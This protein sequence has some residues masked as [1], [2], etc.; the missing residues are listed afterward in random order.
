MPNKIFDELLKEKTDIFKIAFSNISKQIFWDDNKKQLIHPG[1]YGTYREAV[2]K[3]FIRFVIPRRLDIDQG[4]LI[5]SDGDISNQCDIIVYD[6]R[7]APMIETGERQR[8]FPIE[9]VCAIGEV[10]SDMTKGEFINAINKLGEIK[11][12]RDNIVNPFIL[13]S[14]NSNFNP[15]LNHTD[16][17]FTFLICNKFKFDPIDLVNEF[18]SIYTLQSYQKHNLILSLN[19]GLFLYTDS[20][21][22]SI[23]YPV[24]NSVDTKNQYIKTTFND[25][26]HFKIFANN[27]F[28]GTSSAT[29]LF[30]EISS[31]IVPPINVNTILEK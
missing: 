13:N 3:D 19:D 5:N 6:S 8:F 15:Q 17:I 14:E 1:E 4:F 30:P 9:S 26:I 22:N 24:F 21:G 10:K 11:K 29:I 18:S 2:C 31:Y 27:I 7:T 20:Y 16:Q 12:M 28:L 23:P 25:D